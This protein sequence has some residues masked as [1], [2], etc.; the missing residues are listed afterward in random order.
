[1]VTSRAENQIEIARGQSKMS[2]IVY[3]NNAFPSGSPR[4]EGL[5][6]WAPISG[7][8]S[9]TSAAETAPG[10]GSAELPGSRG[11]RGCGGGLADG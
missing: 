9:D 2:V 8:L 11:P 7:A 5:R 4:T 1:M 10:R 6:G 3:L